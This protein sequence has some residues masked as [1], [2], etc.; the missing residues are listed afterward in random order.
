MILKEIK[1]RYSP[2]LFRKNPI[3]KIVLKRCLEAARWTPS[4]N[5]LQ[6]WKFVLV[7]NPKRIAELS[8]AFPAGNHW[9]MKAP[10]V[11][12][13]VS[14]AKSD[15]VIS[16]NNDLKYFQYDC[17]M[18]MMSFA[19]QAENEGLKTHQ[20]AGYDEKQLK[21]IL[22]VPADYRVIIAFAAGYEEKLE[23]YK[24]ELHPRLLERIKNTKRTRKPLRE[25]YSIDKFYT[26]L[27]K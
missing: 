6:P 24:E 3:P 17:G 1:N 10:I 20:M 22:G 4:C 14:S 13:I 23:N 7:E 16:E 9:A 18:A 11:G 27:L 5:N 8:K 19:L 21:K 2:L 15:C 26:P 25:I 12:F